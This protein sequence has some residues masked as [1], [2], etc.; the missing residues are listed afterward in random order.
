MAASHRKD[1]AQ[2]QMATSSLTFTRILHWCQASPFSKYCPAHD[3]FGLRQAR[4][5]GKAGTG[6]LPVIQVRTARLGGRCPW[7]RCWGEAGSEPL[8]RPCT[9]FLPPLRTPVLFMPGWGGHQMVM[10]G[11]SFPLPRSFLSLLEKATFTE[12]EKGMQRSS[13]GMSHFALRWKKHSG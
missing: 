2:K 11:D 3:L 4:V 5:L 9:Q 7:R 8:S 10:E 12:K 1:P 6:V 13:H